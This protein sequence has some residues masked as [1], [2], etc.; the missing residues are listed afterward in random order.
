MKNALLEK[1]KELARG[2]KIVIIKE[3]VIEGE[4]MMTQWSLFVCHCGIM[5]N[6]HKLNDLLAQAIKRL[7]N[8]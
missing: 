2:D 4:S 7:S 6:G 3:Y 1:L 5:L 8:L